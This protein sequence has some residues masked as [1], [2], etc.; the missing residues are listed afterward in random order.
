MSRTFF[1]FCRTVLQLGIPIP[2]LLF[3]V[4]ILTRPEDVVC[5]SQEEGHVNIQA[6]HNQKTPGEGVQIYQEPHAVPG[7]HQPPRESHTPRTY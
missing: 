2:V 7:S 5:I 4:S 1:F 6:L 3:M